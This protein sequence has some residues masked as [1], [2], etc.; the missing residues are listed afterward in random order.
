MNFEEILRRAKMSDQQAIELLLILYQPL[1]MKEAII[2]GI[3][4]ED[5]FQELQIVFINCI[6]KFDV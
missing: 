3:L 2:D 5:L 4:D 6:R 1:M